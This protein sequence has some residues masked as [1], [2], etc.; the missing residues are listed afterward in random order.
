MALGTGYGAR[1]SLGGTRSRPTQ[2][3]RLG[4]TR[5]MRSRPGAPGPV[6]AF[7][8]PV[9][10][11]ARGR[12]EPGGP[13]PTGLG[14]MANPWQALTAWRAARGLPVAD[15]QAPE[16]MA[17]L[18]YD[19]QPMPSMAPG[20]LPEGMAG[21]PY[22]RNPYAQRPGGGM[23]RRLM[24]PPSVGDQLRQRLAERLGPQQQPQLPIFGGG[25]YYPSY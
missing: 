13:S 24:P 25:P 23:R 18:P 15:L 14:R 16:G 19:R 22:D 2:M 9:G 11:G 8:M 6:R 10:V 20:M 1:R 5:T 3:S 12:A 17:G 7:G 4:G 21:L